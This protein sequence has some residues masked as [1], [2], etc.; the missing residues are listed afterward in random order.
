MRIPTGIDDAA[1]RRRLLDE[2]DI[3]IGGGL[4]DFAGKV[5]R[6]GLMGHGCTADN[7]TVLLSA[8]R[9]TKAG[10][11]RTKGRTM[12]A[13]IVNQR[14][15]HELLPM[16]ECI[17]VMAE[18]LRDLS[19]G[20]CILPLR[21]IM[22]LKDKVGALGLMPS[23]WERAGV[24]GLKAVT[25]FPANEGTELDSHQG[26]VLL[27]DAGRGTLLALIDATAIT[28]IRTAAVSGVATRALAREDAS[29]LA[30]LGAGVQARMH[31]EAMLLCRSIKRARVFSKTTSQT[32]AFAKRE[33]ARHNLAI[34]A[35]ETA[36]EAVAGADI[37]CTTTS[38][39]TPVLKGDWVAAGTHVNAVGSSVASARELD[40]SA[41]RMS[42]L[43]VDRRESA[44][45]EAGDFLLARQEG[46]IG[47]DHILAEIGEVLTGQAAG[48]RSDEEITLFKSVGLAVEDLAAAVRI[49]E[50]ARS[51]NVG[52][53]LDFGGDRLASD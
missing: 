53:R 6:I 44:L 47:D 35:A 38:S 46:L 41:V 3:E 51:G 28:A 12:E 7:V 17:D 25:F 11:R 8:L 49:Y 36:R 22:W 13:V 34:E 19:D 21:Q 4:G 18:V 32:T 42:R 50:K 15:V 40:G 33:A 27:F 5:W 52:T 39:N 48:R 10:W 23:Y 20:G 14:Q 1:T 30:I 2:F 31:L 26:A 45:A 9:T 29:T 43:F 37:I 16:C 24:I